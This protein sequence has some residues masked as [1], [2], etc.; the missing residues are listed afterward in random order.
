MSSPDSF[1]PEISFVPF[2]LLNF[3][4]GNPLASSSGVADASISAVGT[5]AFFFASSHAGLFASQ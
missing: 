2:S 4:V 1:C 3:M 5:P